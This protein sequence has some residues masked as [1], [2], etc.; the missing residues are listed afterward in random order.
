MSL[1]GRKQKQKDI[2]VRCSQHK[3]KINF[4]NETDRANITSTTNNALEIKHDYQIKFQKLKEMFEKHANKVNA[5]TNSINTISQSKYKPTSPL[6]KD[7]NSIAGA[8]KEGKNSLPIGEPRIPRMATPPNNS[9]NSSRG[10]NK[11]N[12]TYTNQHK[13]HLNSKDIW[14]ILHRP[15]KEESGTDKRGNEFNIGHNFVNK[16]RQEEN[17]AIEENL[18]EESDNKLIAEGDTKK[19]NIPSRNIGFRS[20]R[21]EVIGN[22][23]NKDYIMPRNTPLLQRKYTN[24]TSNITTTN[25][26]HEEPTEIPQNIIFQKKEEINS[27]QTR[28]ITSAPHY[29][30]DRPTHRS[31]TTNKIFQIPKLEKSLSAKKILH[32]ESL[33]KQDLAIAIK[34]LR[35]NEKKYIGTTFQIKFKDNAEIRNTTNKISISKIRPF[36]EGNNRDNMNTKNNMDM[37]M[38]IMDTN[39]NITN[40][41]TND[42]PNNNTNNNIYRERNTYKRNNESADELRNI[43]Q[44]IFMTN[45]I[46][47][48]SREHRIGLSAG[49]ARPKYKTQINMKPN[50]KPVYQIEHKV[51]YSNIPPDTVKNPISIKYNLY[52]L[53]YVIRSIIYIYIYSNMFRKSGNNRNATRIHSL[54]G[55]AHSFAPGSHSNKFNNTQEFVEWTGDKVKNISIIDPLQNEQL[56]IY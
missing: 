40:N 16:R 43:Q 19:E 7:R 17:K 24:T 35:T 30:I 5:I 4:G 49:S 33:T 53:L 26:K 11:S 55:M 45:R 32:G 1:T 27:L 13:S 36:I 9:L 52:Y 3:T 21:R 2:I 38:D 41:N 14:D 12:H 51:R 47:R 8:V 23:N 37:D 28:P 44:D 25:N 20:F 6:R 29:V 50:S 22:P 48:R 42:D 56:G 15:E 31:I 18:R 54:A 46:P 34:E 10:I 39:N